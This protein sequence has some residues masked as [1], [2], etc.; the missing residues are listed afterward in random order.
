MLGEELEK[1]LKV[2]NL[3]EIVWQ[4]YLQSTSLRHDSSYC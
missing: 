2:G 3:Q 1:L 4:H